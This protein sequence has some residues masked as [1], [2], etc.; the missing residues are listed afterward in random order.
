MSHRVCTPAAQ[1]EAAAAE[2]TRTETAKAK[3]EA[4]ARPLNVKTARFSLA[5]ILVLAGTTGAGG[6]A[7]P[8]SNTISVRLKREIYF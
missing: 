8:A 6:M 7:P 2:R 5:G 3:V 4:E 1:E